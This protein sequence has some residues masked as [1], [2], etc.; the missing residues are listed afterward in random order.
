MNKVY[1]LDAYRYFKVNKLDMR[2]A[3][4]FIR[5]QTD[6]DKHLLG[7]KYARKEIDET[8]YRNEFQLLDRKDVTYV[9]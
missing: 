6:L 7:C 1:S 2:D 5:S 8:T 3:T 4:I 9:G